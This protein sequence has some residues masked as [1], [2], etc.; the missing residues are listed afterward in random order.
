MRAIP[1][2]ATGSVRSERSSPAN[3]PRWSI[4]WLCRRSDVATKTSSLGRGPGI[5]WF[6]YV[7]VAALS[8]P[9]A[10]YSSR[11]KLQ[12]CKTIIRRRQPVAISHP[13][14]RTVTPRWTSTNGIRPRV[15]C[16]TTKSRRSSFTVTKSVE[17]DGRNA[18]PKGS[19]QRP[20]VTDR[21]SDIGR[22]IGEQ[23]DTHGEDLI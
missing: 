22:S 2:N 1:D 21:D 15:L 23:S 13:A 7:I 20:L 9:S 4:R 6:H 18:E 17:L 3:P 19:V 14:V 10:G 12:A 11:G 8:H 16:A 5:G